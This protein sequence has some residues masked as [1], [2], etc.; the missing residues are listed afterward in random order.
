MGLTADWENNIYKSLNGHD[1]LH[2]IA[3]EFK[4]L[5]LDLEDF[6]VNYL[7]DIIIDKSKYH[8]FE[9]VLLYF[10]IYWEVFKDYPKIAKYQSLP[11]PY[12]SIFKIILRGNHIYKGEMNTIEIDHCPV[13]R[14][15]DFFMPSL[16]ADFLNYVDIVVVRSGSDGIPNQEQI[17]VLWEKFKLS[18]KTGV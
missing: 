2:F 13:K 15:T 18:N 14:Q 9:Y 12:E 7:D 1:L 3:P 10:S 8:G 17:H 4:E 16:D 11:N 5:R 6:R